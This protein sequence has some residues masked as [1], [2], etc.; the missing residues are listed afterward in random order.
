MGHLAAPLLHLLLVTRYE[1]SYH[2][3]S[4]FDNFSACRKYLV[5]NRLSFPSTPR[6]VRHS[7]LSKGLGLIP[8]TCVSSRLFSG[9]AAG[10]LSALGKWKSVRKNLYYMRKFIVT[11]YYGEQS[12]EGGLRDLHEQFEGLQVRST[13]IRL[14]IL[15]V[16]SQ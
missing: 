16:R 11:F 8:Y 14:L 3:T 4:C 12:F 6:W 13:L 15:Q 9:A 7:C 5:V 1:L 10:E 2:K